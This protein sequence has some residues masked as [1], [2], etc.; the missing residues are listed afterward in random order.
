M[1]DLAELA[2]ALCRLL[3]NQGAAV[4]PDPDTGAALRCALGRGR[5]VD[6]HFQAQQQRWLLGVGCASGM[7]DAARRA[8]SEEALLRVGHASRWGLQQTA[9]GD[10]QGLQLVDC[11]FCAAPAQLTAA[12]VEQQL[13]ALLGQLDA[14][15]EG[16]D[17]APGAPLE[18]CA[19]PRPDCGC[20][21]AFRAR[22]QALDASRAPR[23]V[24]AQELLLEPQL[25]VR[26]SL[27]PCSHH[28]VFEAFVGDASVLA[29][30]LRR[31]LVAA[32]LL[33][34]G[35]VLTGRLLVCSL[36]GCDRVVV[37]S[38]WHLDWAAQ[39]PL[40]DWLD[41]STRQAQRIRAAVAA[42]A[43]HDDGGRLP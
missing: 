43:M 36:D 39:M 42:I 25:P 31:S 23:S 18:R 2:P 3:Q 5:W 11:D 4:A 34:N 41:Y 19:A 8:R 15:A 21:Q 26:I 12:A 10:G 20:A 7:W 6:L 1:N 22:M 40:L 33:V 13:Q 27:H 29:G 30:P 17:M 32:L 9:L 14:V 35:A 16:D 37:I 38:R 24:A 28:W